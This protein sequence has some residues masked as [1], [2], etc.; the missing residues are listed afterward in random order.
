MKKV[1]FVIIFIIIYSFSSFS[2]ELEIKGNWKFKIADN[3][4]FS[5]P[6]FDD[7][8]WDELETLRLTDSDNSIIWIRK[9][10]FIPSS[11][12]EEL[13]KTGALTLSMGKIQRSDNTYFNGKLIGSNANE[14]YNRNY[15]INSDDILW[16][17]ENTIAIR[18]VYK[19]TFSISQLPTLKS[20]TPEHYLVY[21]AEIKNGDSKA[22]VNIK[23][24]VF[25]LSIY[26]KSDKAANGTLVADF[27][28]IEGLKIHSVQKEVNLS[29]GD[30]TYDFPFNSPSPFLKIIYSVSIPEYK[31]SGEWNAEYGYE[32]IVYEKAIPKINY[33][34]TQNF[35]SAELGK[36][37]IE[38]WLGTKMEINLKKRLH[39]VDEDAILEGYINRPGNHLWI[40]EH[41]GKFLEAACNSY[42]YTGDSILKNQIDRSAQQLIAT[43]LNDGYLGTYDETSQWTRWDVWSHKYNL[44]GLLRYYELSGY[45]PALEASIKVGDLLSNIFG[46][47]LG[48]KSIIESGS[49]VGMAATSILDPMTDLYR[50]S[51]NKRYLDFCNY[52]VE[53]YND[54]NGPRI[55]SSLDSLGRVDKVANGKA[56]EMLS[57][58]VGITKLYQLTKNEKLIAPVLLAWNDI[59]DNRLYITGASSSFEH[60]HDDHILPAGDN[61]NVGEGCV[62]TTWTQLNYQLFS[63]FGDLKYL[64]EL[65]RVVYNH[66]IG[67]ESPQ[68]GG[69]SYFTPLM[70]TKN[71]RT[72]ITCCMSSIPRGI[73]MIPLFANGKINHIPTFLFYQPGVYKT[74][75]DNKNKTIV[76]FNTVTSFPQSGNI[77]ITVHPEKSAKFKVSF[78]IPYWANDFTIS[79]NNKMEKRT[80]NLT[81]IDRT[82]KKGDN[83]EIAFSTPLQV[84][85]GDISYPGQVA[86]QRG[87]QILAFDEK[88]NKVMADDILL[89]IENLHLK[90]AEKSIL[91]NVWSGK[92]AYQVNAQINGK[93]KK[94]I[95]V[96]FADAG[97]TGG[98]ISTWLKRKN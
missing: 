49:H 55:I 29:I 34:V 52:I 42:A 40:G 59:I 84:L 19:G 66:L 28:N 68:T 20:A 74:E 24:L 97:Q 44:V 95:L 5:C 83:I 26:N 38:G 9:T 86:I 51:G 33:Q 63:I 62:S 78:R 17:K 37:Q 88:L 23:G 4:D 15:L 85:D 64:D 13:E 53:S 57:N 79:V 10:V 91:P 36:Q 35:E 43:Q 16:D 46:K 93:E 3:K 82:W 25:N 90:Q 47:E 58:I 2:Q 67:A 61:D 89:D 92:Q 75:I 18:V 50:F 76:E 54:H 80:N 39:L 65:E 30:N 72:D 6:K 32:N 77:S 21:I 41:I 71:Y 7:S 31:Y 73:A 1:L 60:F 81:T 87:P 56:Y 11:M 8:S 12:K 70:G 94:I 69:V 98:Q 27:Y 96:P 14:L 22:P 48:K 45:K